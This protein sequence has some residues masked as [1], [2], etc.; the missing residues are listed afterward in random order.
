VVLVELL[1]ASSGVTHSLHAVVNEA[2]TSK[3]V[4]HSCN[5]EEWKATKG[6]VCGLEEHVNA[7]ESGCEEVYRAA[8]TS[9]WLVACPC[10]RR[11]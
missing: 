2:S 7:A 5:T 6:R 8:E 4:D 9:R 3:R 11:G 1:K 10:R